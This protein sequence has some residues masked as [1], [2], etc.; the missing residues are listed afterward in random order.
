MHRWERTVFNNKK[1]VSHSSMTETS[2]LQNCTQPLEVCDPVQ[3]SQAKV[4]WA[5]FVQES[6]ARCLLLLW[7]FEGEP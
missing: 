1:A 2:D 5:G 3:A 4:R 6:Y 7:A